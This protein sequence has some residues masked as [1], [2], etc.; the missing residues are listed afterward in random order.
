KSP[1]DASAPSV[2]ASVAG[3]DPPT[4]LLTLVEFSGSVTVTGAEA[5]DGLPVA[6]AWVAVSVTGPAGRAGAGVHDQVPSAATVAVQPGVVPF[7]TVTV[8]PGTPLPETTGLRLAGEDPSAGDV[9]AGACA[10]TSPTTVCVNSLPL[11]VRFNA[12]SIS[13]VPAI[14]L[15]TWTVAA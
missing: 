11:L 7:H 15:A 4:V 1:N 2:S 8:S 13:H 14:G 6:S 10:S 12:T 5:A 3:A 9:I